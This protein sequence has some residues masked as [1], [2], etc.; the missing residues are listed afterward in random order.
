MIKKG[1]LY[2]CIRTVHMSPSNDIA[3]KAGYIYKSEKDRCITDEFGNKDHLWEKPNIYFRQ[4]SKDLKISYL[5]PD[6]TDVRKI[7]ILI[8][9]LLNLI[10]SCTEQ[11]F[12]NELYNND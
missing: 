3:Y 8:L 12:N 4:I 2:M 9:D 7:L 1:N 11:L 5:D 10:H 6:S